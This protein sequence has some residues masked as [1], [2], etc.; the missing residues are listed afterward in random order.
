MHFSKRSSQ[1]RDQ[2]HGSYLLHWQAGCLPLASPGSLLQRLQWL[3]KALRTKSQ[4]LNMMSR[5]LRGVALLLNILNSHHSPHLHRLNCFQLLEEYHQLSHLLVFALT[6]F[7]S[8]NILFPPP[9]LAKSSLSFSLSHQE[10][11]STCPA[12][13]H[14]RPS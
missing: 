10:V 5:V 2:N 3:P 4:T 6:I 1:P 14:P 12:A 11:F 9:H 13:L 7:P 8:W